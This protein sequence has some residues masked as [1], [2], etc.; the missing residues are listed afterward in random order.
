MALQA[1]NQVALGDVPDTDSGV[2]AG[3]PQFGLVW[4]EVNPRQPVGVTLAAGNQISPR[5]APKLPQS[6]VA[7]GR[8]DTLAW[9]AGEAADGLAVGLCGE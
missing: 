2:P 4:V 9:V 3:G 7:R 8:Q 6:V 5:Q 1:E